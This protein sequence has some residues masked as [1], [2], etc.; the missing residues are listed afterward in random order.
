VA[1]E[2]VEIELTMLNYDPDQWNERRIRLGRADAAA[3]EAE[4]KENAEKVTHQVPKEFLGIGVRIEDSILATDGGSENM[5][6]S[7]P[8]EIDEVEALCAEKSSLPH[9]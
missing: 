5:T 1:P 8:V 4:E 7:V 6:S 2:K 9:G 3:K